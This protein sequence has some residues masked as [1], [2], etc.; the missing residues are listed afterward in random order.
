MCLGRGPALVRRLP[1]RPLRVVI[2]FA[3]IILAVRLG[4]A[5]YG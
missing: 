5:A 3:G 2:G 4:I 1:G